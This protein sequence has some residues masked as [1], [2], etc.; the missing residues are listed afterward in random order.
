MRQLVLP[1]HTWRTKCQWS[2]ND[3]YLI[4]LFNLN[5]AGP[6]SGL[7]HLIFVSIFGGHQSFLQ[8][9]WYPCFRLLDFKA[10]VVPSFVCFLPVHDKFLRFKFGVAPVNIL[11]AN[12]AVKPLWSTYFSLVGLELGSRVRHTTLSELIPK[13]DLVSC[14]HWGI[15]IALA[16]LI[17]PLM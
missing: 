15:E 8:G 17:I 16:R 12:M 11:T 13:S 14:R 6:W 9:H 4:N 7:L 3:F 5:Y 1:V 2:N 10:R